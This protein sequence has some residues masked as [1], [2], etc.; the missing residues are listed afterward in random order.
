ML[1][2]AHLGRAR[3][4]I[5]PPRP[6]ARSS[7][8]ATARPSLAAPLSGVL[9]PSPKT[10][11]EIAPRG[12]LPDPPSGPLGSLVPAKRDSSA[13]TAG[14]TRRLLGLLGLSAFSGSEGPCGRAVLMGL[15][16]FS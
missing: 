7:L 2:P 10:P 9:S 4:L 15:T 3:A 14:P 16:G 1:L 8:R 12:F 11:S 5:G 13:R 6:T